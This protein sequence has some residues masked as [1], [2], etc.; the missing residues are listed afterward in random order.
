[1]LDSFHLIFLGE[2]GMDAVNVS[3]GVDA[4]GVL[5]QSRVRLAPEPIC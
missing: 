5:E 3:G 2:I 4:L 1:V